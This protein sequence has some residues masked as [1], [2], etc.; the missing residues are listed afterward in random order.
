MRG[1]R[2]CAHHAVWLAWALAPGC[3][4]KLHVP[5]GSEIACVR[6]RDCPEAYFCDA[7]VAVCV[8]ATEVAPSLTV[9]PIAR[10]ARVVEIPID[11]LDRQGDL[12]TVQVEADTGSG[13]API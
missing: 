11:V 9:G 13:F 12:V 7:E 6:D 3:S 2:S 8:P 5:A 10:H 1:G 4:P